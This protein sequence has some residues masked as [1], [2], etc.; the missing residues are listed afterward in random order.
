LVS[1]D[2]L[3]LALTKVDFIQQNKLGGAMWW[4]V[5]GDKNDT[6]SIISNVSPHLA[7]FPHGC[8]FPQ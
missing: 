6:G 5:S 1:Y 3:D 8:V 7:K 2:T 4:E